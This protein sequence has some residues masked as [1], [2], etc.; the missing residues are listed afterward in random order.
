MA[1]GRLRTRFRLGIVHGYASLARIGL[2]GRY[3]CAA[4]GTVT[5]CGAREA[6]VGQIVVSQWVVAFSR[7]FEGLPRR[8]ETRP[9]SPNRRYAATSGLKCRTSRL[10]SSADPRQ[11]HRPF[12]HLPDHDQPVPL[13]RAQNDQIRVDKSRRLTSS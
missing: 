5:D 7:L 12:R 10:S 13:L 3:D 4:I 8:P 1:T 2:E 9:R 11:L 6:A